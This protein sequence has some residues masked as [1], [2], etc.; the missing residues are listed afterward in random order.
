M[1]NVALAAPS[2]ET[3]NVRQNRARTNPQRHRKWL[4]SPSTDWNRFRRHSVNVQHTSRPTTRAVSEHN[5]N[6]REIHSTFR[7][8]RSN[9]LWSQDTSQKTY[10]WISLIC[11]PG[12]VPIFDEVPLSMTT[13]FGLQTVLETVLSWFGVHS[14]KFG[15]MSELGTAKRR[16]CA[17]QLFRRVNK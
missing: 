8:N 4:G 15:Y 2:S 12:S 5:R 14:R 13:W 7:R 11:D 6:K 10:E 9:I 1:R 17:M 16:N 3:V